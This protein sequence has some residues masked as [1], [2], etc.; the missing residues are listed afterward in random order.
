MSDKHP[1]IYE[2]TTAITDY[3][4]CILSFIFGWITLSIQD[5]HFHQLW[6][7]SFILIGIGALFGGTSHGFGPKISE[8]S[9]AIIWRLTLIFVASTAIV[10]AMSPTL[11]FISGRGVNIIYG[12]GSLLLITFYNKSRTQTSFSSVVTFYLPLMMISLI[13]FILVFV[14][15]GLTGALF[16][17]IGLV[18]SL[19]ASWVQVAKISLHKHFNYNGLFHVIQLLGIY[20]MYRGGIEIRPF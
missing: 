17:A 5:S 4:I 2:P 13:G 6:G 7:T 9:N 18:V 20:L 12:I 14:F 19:V 8:L 1:H 3:I 16:I 11:F 10:L 15:F